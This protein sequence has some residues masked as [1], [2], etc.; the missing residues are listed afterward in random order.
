M[1]E[2]L[3]R[4]VGAAVLVSLLVVAADATSRGSWRFAARG[5]GRVFRNPP[6][7]RWSATCS[8]VADR[9][10]L[11]RIF[12]PISC[13]S[14]TVSSALDHLL[15]CWWVR[16]SADASRAIRS[17]ACLNESPCTI[18]GPG[19]SFWRPSSVMVALLPCSGWFRAVAACAAMV[20]GPDLV[21]LNPAL[22]NP[23]GGRSANMLSILWCTPGPRH[24]MAGL[25][26]RL[27]RCRD[28]YAPGS[29]RPLGVWR[30]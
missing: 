29:A 30:C 19:L 16:H 25:D 4:V 27:H 2:L 17:L 13:R 28:R 26:R 12:P 24:A 3:L 22:H 1:R 10:H 5:T 9:R 8:L 23:C 6:S 18:C 20:T 11:C 14:S 21:T 15:G 7:A